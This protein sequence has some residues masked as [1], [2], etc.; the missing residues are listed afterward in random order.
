MPRLSRLTRLGAAYY[1]VL[2]IAIAVGLM[3]GGGTGDTIVAISA[4]IFALTIFVAFGGG[5]LASRDSIDRRGRSF[6]RP[7]D[8]EEDPDRWERD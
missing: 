2:V 7:L 6:G 1:A 3:I 4:A 8:E 5:G